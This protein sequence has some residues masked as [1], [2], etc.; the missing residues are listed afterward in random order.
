MGRRKKVDM[1]A[2]AQAPKA[3]SSRSPAWVL[4]ARLDPD[5]ESCVEAYI[6]SREYA[7]SK[8]QVIERALK[9]LLAEEGFWPP[10]PPK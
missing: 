4:Y 3:S 1:P 8:A 6:K 10:K 9:K 2:T 5:L 7:P